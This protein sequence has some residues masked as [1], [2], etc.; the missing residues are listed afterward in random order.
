MTRPRFVVGTGRCGSTL[1]TQMLGRHRS[2]CGLNE[3]FT[4]LDWSARFPTEPV[5]GATVAD[6]LGAPN[7]VIQMVVGKGYDAEEVTYPFD[8]R[9]RRRR[10]DPLPWI[11]T[12]T[13]GHLHDDPD[14]YWD[15]LAAWMRSRPVMPIAAHYA[16][17]FDRLT[18]D[19]GKDAWVERSG[20]SIDYVG[21]L[22]ALFPDALV[23]HIWRTPE[24]VALS[25]RRHP[26]YRLAV[27]LTYGV[28]PPGVDP[29]D[30]DAVVSG[31][32]RGD[33]PAAL[34]G[35]YVSDQL[36][37]GEAALSSLPADRLDSVRFERVVADPRRAM[38]EL[39]DFLELP[40]DPEFVADAAALVRGSPLPRV[41]DLA[42]DERADLETACS[43]G[44][45]VLGRLGLG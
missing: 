2:M 38:T 21:D 8:G 16:A 15:E 36:A 33:P 5:S 13:L 42:S 14:G 39:S 31:W 17:F 4:G 1:L 24:E 6:I 20:S 10:G 35:R 27:Q 18:R 34:Y 45:E 22:L 37:H 43:V 3:V 28:M 30:D 32:L 9:G 11:L 26:F 19:A 40:A 12:S 25:M 7:E 23:V 29:D 44:R 41:G